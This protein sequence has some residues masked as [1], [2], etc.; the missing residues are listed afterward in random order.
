MPESLDV[1]SLVRRTA[2]SVSLEPLSESSRESGRKGQKEKWKEPLT[3]KT[4][5][6]GPWGVKALALHE[7]VF[8]L[9]HTL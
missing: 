1:V 4:R 9:R 2:A 7:A 5:W 3:E 6:G 8:T